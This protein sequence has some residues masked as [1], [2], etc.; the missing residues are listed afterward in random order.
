[1]QVSAEENMA[2]VIASCLK[3]LDETETAFVRE[4]YLSDQK[5]T[6]TQFA[7]RWRLST[8]AL[9]ELRSRVGVRFKELLAAK[10]IF[11]IGDLL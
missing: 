1:M 10:N 4:Y 7:K 3:Q 5:T 11:S 9:S 6:L 8:K 2:I